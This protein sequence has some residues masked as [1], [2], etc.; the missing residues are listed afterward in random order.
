MKAAGDGDVGA[1]EGTGLHE[2]KIRKKE[3]KR[4]RENGKTTREM[5]EEIEDGR[6]KIEDWE[7]I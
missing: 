2:F 6:L 4:K 7:C 3:G 1:E 5:A